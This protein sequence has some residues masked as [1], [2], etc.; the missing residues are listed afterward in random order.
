MY[1]HT[2]INVNS[3]LFKEALNILDNEIKRIIEKVYNDEFKSGEVTLKL[4]IGLVEDSKEF[5]VQDELGFNDNKVVYF[6]RPVIEHN[7]SSTLK[8][9]YREKGSISLASEIKKTDEGS[10]VLVPV[11]DPQLNMITDGFLK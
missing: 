10:F 11:E 2:E 7:V 6:N 8:K 1:A 9:Q 5:P 3:P 4:N